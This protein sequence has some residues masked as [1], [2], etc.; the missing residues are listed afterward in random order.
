MSLRRQLLK[1]IKWDDSSK[2]TIVYRYPMEDRD[3]IMNGCQLIVAESQVAILVSM[4]QI[5]DVYGPGEHKL[6]T[7]NMPILTKLAS[8]KYGFDS[9]FKADVYYINTKQ[10][11]NQKWGTAS[12]INMRDADFG[13]VRVGGRGTFSFRVVDAAQFMRE[14]FGTN[15]SYKTAD[16]I[17]YFKSIL[18]ANFTKVL[19]EA[20]IPVIDIPAKYIE[21]GDL[22][23]AELKDDFDAIGLDICNFYVEAITLPEEIEKAIDKRGKIGIMGDVVDTYTKLQ[24]A[25]AI[26][27]AAQNEGGGGVGAGVGIG[28]GLAAGQIIAGQVGQT[29]QPTPAA[30]PVTPA[31]APTAGTCTGCGQPLPAGAKFCPNCGTA[32]AVK[33]FCTNCGFELAAGAKFCPNCGTKVE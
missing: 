13:I 5:G 11:I 9:P 2:D 10:F 8:W 12:K 17:E 26:L 29:T 7:G 14:I 19:G 6:T 4:G 16:L 22:T 27:A 30:A 23:K 24:T 28:V 21:I 3:E 25:D 15:R 32:V 31:A 18:V 33:K 20:R 1:V